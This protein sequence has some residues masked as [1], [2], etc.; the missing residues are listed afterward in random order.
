MYV[1]STGMPVYSITLYYNGWRK[2]LSIYVRN[3]SVLFFMDRR[4]GKRT[5]APY[6]GEAAPSS[7]SV[8]L[9]DLRRTVKRRVPSVEIL[10]IHVVLCYPQR[11]TEITLLHGSSYLRYQ[12]RTAAG[13]EK[14]AC[15]IL[16]EKI[17][18]LRKM[19]YTIRV[20]RRML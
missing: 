8:F 3:I 13:A 4:Q 11:F 6:S 12:T 18:I 1:I 16:M 15:S 20:H 5:A 7:C 2:D 10:R 17:D 9:P 14:G 19:W